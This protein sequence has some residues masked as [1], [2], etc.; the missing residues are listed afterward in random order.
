MALFIVASPS[1]NIPTKSLLSPFLIHIH[2]IFV[3]AVL[4]Y[5]YHIHFLRQVPLSPLSLQTSS[6]HSVPTDIS[7]YKFNFLLVL[8]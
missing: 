2:K 8:E 7:Y 4:L 1:P 5:F 3:I 6:T